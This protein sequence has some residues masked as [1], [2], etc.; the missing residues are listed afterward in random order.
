MNL[1]YKIVWI[2]LAISIVGILLLYGLN[3]L[4]SDKF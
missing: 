4:S 2:I 1:I 3:F